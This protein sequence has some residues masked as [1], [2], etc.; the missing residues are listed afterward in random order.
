MT[1]TVSSGLDELRATMVGAALLPGDPG[2]DDARSI[3]NGEIDRRPAVIAR[4]ESGAD[5]V[6]AVGFAQRAGL[7]IAV[8]GGGH[9]FS[10]SSVCEGGLMIDLSRLRGVRVD[11]DR[12]R[13]VVGGGATLA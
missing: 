12:R 6:A 5:V 1:Q 10:G 11:P 3:W 2:Y 7:E 9:A 13:A 8:R 4:C